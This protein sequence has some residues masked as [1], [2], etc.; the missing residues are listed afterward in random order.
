VLNDHYLGRDRPLGEARV[1]W[2]IGSQGCDVRRLRSHLD[3]DSGYLSRLLRSLERAGL[4]TVGVNGHDRRV[5]TVRLTRRGAAERAVLDRRS[6][7]LARSMVEPLTEDQ[8]G[9]LT[10]AMDEVE[11]LLTLAT[12]AF[13]VIDPAH[14]DAQDCL[15]RYYVELDQRF[16][17]GFDPARTRP[18]E[19]DQMRLPAGLFLLAS[20]RG[21]PVGCGALLFHGSDPAEL[22]RM[23]VAPEARGIGLGRRLLR[24]LETLTQNHGARV[25]RLDSNGALVEAIAMYRASGYQEIAAFNDEPYADHWFEKRLR[26]YRGRHGD[27]VGDR[28]LRG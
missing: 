7:A 15:S 13:E 1:L 27:D 10:T 26:S 17:A 3:L 18:T 25:I 16:G 24:E 12:V 22:K 9:R 6:I 14:R 8:R 23:W 20:L 4:V 28:A 19:P 2:E 11:R 5:R 21:E